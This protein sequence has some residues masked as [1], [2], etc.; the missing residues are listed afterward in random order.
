MHPPYPLEAIWH[1]NWVCPQFNVLVYEF[2]PSV[3]WLYVECAKS[4][5]EFATALTVK[6]LSNQLSY[7]DSGAP[8]NIQAFTAALLHTFNLYSVEF[9]ARLNRGRVGNVSL[10]LAGK[11][12]AIAKNP[13]PMRFKKSGISNPGLLVGAGWLLGDPTGGSESGFASTFCAHTVRRDAAIA[14]KRTFDIS[15]ADLKYLEGYSEGNSRRRC[16]YT[17]TGRLSCST[18]KRRCDVVNI[19]SLINTQCFP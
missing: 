17:R 16:S 8:E 2:H 18:P 5:C 4:H 11:S 12:C 10:V 9:G 13:K 19:Q 7:F 6:N 1:S 3:V 14:T 15:I